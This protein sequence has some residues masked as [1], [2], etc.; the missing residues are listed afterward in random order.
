MGARVGHARYGHGVT[1]Y[2]SPLRMALPRR[3]VGLPAPCWRSRSAIGRCGGGAMRKPARR[4]L[5]SA[6]GACGTSRGVAAG[7]GLRSCHRP[8]AQSG[9]TDRCRQTTRPQTA[10]RSGEP[11]FDA[12]LIAKA[13]R[14]PRRRTSR[15]RRPCQLHSRFHSVH[16]HRPAAVRTA[17]WVWHRDLKRSFGPARGAC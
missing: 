14:T 13:S 3:R 6:E 10:L 17:G 8:G 1:E 4:R 7:A 11:S 16:F 5:A 9:T 2:L 12:V 15:S